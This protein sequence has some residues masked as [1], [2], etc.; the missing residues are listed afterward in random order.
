MAT[1]A[2]AK[3]ACTMADNIFMRYYFFLLYLCFIVKMFRSSHFPRHK[4]KYFRNSQ[5]ASVGSCL[6]LDRNLSV[7]GVAYAHVEHNISATLFG[8]PSSLARDGAPS[9]DFLCLFIARR[10]F[11]LSR[12][13]TRGK[14]RSCTPFAVTAY[15]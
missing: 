15:A 14:G 13:E 6:P 12:E 8:S 10:R 3:S 7:T 4:T 2:A 1:T 5:W 11:L 9:C